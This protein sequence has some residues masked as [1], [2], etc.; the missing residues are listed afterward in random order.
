MAGELIV[1]I[2]D[3]RETLTMLE[4]L[5]THAGYH[6]IPQADFEA[7]YQRIWQ[8]QPDLVLCDLMVGV[9]E[10]GWT[11]VSVL[12]A[13]PATAHI[14]AILYSA[15]TRFLETRGD[16]LRR[17][18]QCLALPKPFTPEQLLGTIAHALGQGAFMQAREVA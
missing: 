5:L 11:M 14:P 18:K 10:A 2:D 17:R 12:R 6:V 15:N 8:T 1:V 7:A 16:L 4:L 9:T 3:D 13:D